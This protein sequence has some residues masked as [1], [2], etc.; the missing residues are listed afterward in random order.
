MSSD[1]SQNDITHY[2]SNHTVLTLNNF[3][4]ILTIVYDALTHFKGMKS[5]NDVL[6]H[7]RTNKIPGSKNLK[8]IPRFITTFPNETQFH[9]FTYVARWKERNIFGRCQIRIA[10]LKE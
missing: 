3:M 4:T 5:L 6:Y 7:L 1:I 8:E 9:H 2:L 10:S